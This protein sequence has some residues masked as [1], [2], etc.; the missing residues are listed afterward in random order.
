M[1]ANC[2]SS[3][4][5]IRTAPSRCVILISNVIQRSRRVLHALQLL[6]EALIGERQ[7]ILEAPTV[8]GGIA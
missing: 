8:E 1:T 7:A 3:E 6:R 2:T 4:P 5:V